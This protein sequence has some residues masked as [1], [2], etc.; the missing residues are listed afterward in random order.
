MSPKDIGPY[1]EF[2][3]SLQSFTVYIFGFLLFMFGPMI[4]PEAPIS[5]ALS[6]LIATCFAAFVVVVYLTNLYRVTG[7]EVVAMK[8]FPKRLEQRARLDRIRRVDLRRG[9]VQRLTGVAHVHIY[10]DGQEEPAV[11]LFGVARPDQFRRL[12]LELG[13]RD[14]RVTGAWR[15]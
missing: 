1:A 14:E 4:N 11:K 7:Y 2:R 10:V 13:A 9:I 15:K 3:P 12:L 5:P 8:T 6:Q